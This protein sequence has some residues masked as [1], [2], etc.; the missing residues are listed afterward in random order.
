MATLLLLG[1]LFQR[2]H[3]TRS[4]SLKE[5]EAIFLKR[6]FILFYS[7]RSIWF[8]FCFGLNI[9]IRKISNLLLTL[10]FR[11][12]GIYP[13]RPLSKMANSKQNFPFLESGSNDCRQNP[14]ISVEDFEFSIESRSRCLKDVFKSFPDAIMGKIFVDVFTFQHYFPS[15]QVKRNYITITKKWIYELPNDLRFKILG[16]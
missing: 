8:V 2:L 14:W 16:N 3:E 6:H 9:F 11:E 7:T 12:P 13:K 4:D 15:S 1:Y 5:Y 10:G